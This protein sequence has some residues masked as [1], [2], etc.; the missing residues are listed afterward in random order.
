MTYTQQISP[1]RLVQQF[2]CVIRL[3]EREMAAKGSGDKY[4][5]QKQENL[6]KPGKI[7]NNP[8]NH[9]NN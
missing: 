1:N 9:E 4:T 7:S 5:I 2:T 8:L 6:I 3:K